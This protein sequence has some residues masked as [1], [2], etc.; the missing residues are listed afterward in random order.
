MANKRDTFCGSTSTAVSTT[1]RIISAP[2]GTDGIDI[3]HAVT[4]ITIITIDENSSEI[5]FKRAIKIVEIA[6]K[7]AVPLLFRV[8]P[9]ESTNLEIRSSQ[10]TLLIMQ[11]VATGS[12]IAL[13]IK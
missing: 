8:I 12:A 9:S 7:K 13:K 11:L 5:P 4:V 3:E 1:N 10:R 6:K 2:P